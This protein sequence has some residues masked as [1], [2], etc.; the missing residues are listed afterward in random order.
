[1]LLPGGKKEPKINFL[2]LAI[3]MRCRMGFREIVV[4]GEAQGG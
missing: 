4:V 2:F 1:M 3:T